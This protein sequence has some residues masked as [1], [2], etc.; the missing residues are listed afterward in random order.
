M[1]VKLTHEDW[2]IIKAIIQ[3]LAGFVALM[4]WLFMVA[5]NRMEVEIRDLL[6]LALSLLGSGS[7]VAN[8]G[9][10]RSK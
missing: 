4:L 7:G 2:S 3:T 5:T 6:L 10:L 1:L 8:L 9:K